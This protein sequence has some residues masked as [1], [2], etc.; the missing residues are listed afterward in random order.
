[1][2]SHLPLRSAFDGF[3]AVAAFAPMLKQ[4]AAGGDGGA[5]STANL[6][7]PR[8]AM[9]VWAAP[10]PTTDDS[11]TMSGDDE[12]LAVLR[13]VR[14]EDGGGRLLQLVAERQR[15]STLRQTGKARRR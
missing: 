3:L 5:P 4:P 8:N 11:A 9:T 1:M 2:V 15:G 12:R 10:R 6:C 7:E 13:S 14:T